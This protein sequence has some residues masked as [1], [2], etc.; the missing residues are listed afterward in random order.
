MISIHLVEEKGLG[1]S[2]TARIFTRLTTIARMP[3]EMIIR[4]NARPSDSWLMASVFRLPSTATPRIIMIAARAKKP[5]SSPNMGHRRLKKSRKN[6]SSV[7]MR[8]TV[9]GH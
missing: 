8:A 3:A 6:G 1:I 4:Q 9:N 5:A 2:L 7:T